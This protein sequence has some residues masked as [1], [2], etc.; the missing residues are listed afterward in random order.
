MPASLIYLM[1]Q[2]LLALV[3]LAGCRPVY[4]GATSIVEFEDGEKIALLGTDFRRVLDQLGE[5]TD[6]ISDKSEPMMWMY[7]VDETGS[8]PLLIL[9]ALT[10]GL[11]VKRKILMIEFDHNWRVVG[12]DI[13]RSKT[14]IVG[15][16]GRFNLLTRQIEAKN[17]V[18]SVLNH[19][20]LKR[21]G[22]R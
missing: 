15:L 5:P 7:E 4:Y 6:I 1:C 11:P 21:S 17:R 19:L 20:K 8:N 14:H 9:T 2:I 16:I 18:K 10:S 22:T 12:S 13:E 3:L